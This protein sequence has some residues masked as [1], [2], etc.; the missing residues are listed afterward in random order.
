LMER[1]SKDFKRGENVTSVL[2]PQ[3]PSLCML[4]NTARIR[5][6]ANDWV[7]FSS[8][9]TLSFQFSIAKTDCFYS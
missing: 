9:F 5:T 7:S 3:D 2:N 6:W 8:S 1:F 4:L